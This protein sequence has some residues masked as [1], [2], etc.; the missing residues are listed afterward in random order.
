VTG[1]EKD[2]GLSRHDSKDALV[3]QHVV[4]RRGIAWGWRTQVDMRDLASAVSD[5][6]IDPAKVEFSDGYARVRDV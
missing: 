1:Y 6:G 3:R 4:H 2:T 5:L